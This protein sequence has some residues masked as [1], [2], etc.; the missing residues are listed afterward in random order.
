MKKFISILFLV[1]L[2]SGCAGK[3]ANPISTRQP[4]DKDLDCEDLEVELSQLDKQAKRLLGEQSDKTGY[5]AAI[6]L[7]GL[8]IWPVWFALDLSDAERQEAQAMQD[9]YHYLERLANK[10]DCDLF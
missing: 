4:G 2:V 6:G 5:N 10:K 8:I 1:F 7:T 3:T 9:R